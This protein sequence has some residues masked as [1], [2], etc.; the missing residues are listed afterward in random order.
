MGNP[1]PVAILDPVVNPDPVGYRSDCKIHVGINSVTNPGQFSFLMAVIN[2]DPVKN[3]VTNPD[4]VTTDPF[5][6]LD[7][8]TKPDPFTKPD[9]RTNRIT[10]P[11][12]APNPFTNLDSE[13]EPDR[14]SEPDWESEPDGESEQDPVSDPDLEQDPDLWQYSDLIE[15]GLLPLT[16]LM[17]EAILL[18]TAAVLLKT[19]E[20]SGL[21]HSALKLSYLTLAVRSTPIFV[22]EIRGVNTA[23][24]FDSVTNL[25]ANFRK[26]VKSS[27]C[28]FTSRGPLFETSYIFNA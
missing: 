1:Y 3:P 16:L 27:S 20:L 5:S 28:H 19:A 12:L 11:G 18:R 23:I 8:V 9:P 22:L 7:P 6:K 15:S 21:W 10:Y 26:I 4:W 14:E 2:P 25:S 24:S 13:P 17:L